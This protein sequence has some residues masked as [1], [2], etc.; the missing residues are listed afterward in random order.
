MAEAF[1][2]LRYALL[3]SDITHAI[4]EIL[5]A[6]LTSTLKAFNEETLNTGLAV[7]D[8]I[9]FNLIYIKTLSSSL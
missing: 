7:I 9:N 1:K 4:L 5:P 2:I 8:F 3:L 6:I